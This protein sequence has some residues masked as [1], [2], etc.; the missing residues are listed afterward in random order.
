MKHSY[1][2][3]QGWTI[4]KLGWAKEALQKVISSVIPSTQ[5]AR[6]GKTD[7]E[8]MNKQTKKI[9]TTLTSESRIEMEIDGEG[10]WGNF[11]G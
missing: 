9:R 3:Q 11:M 4:K 6:R 7:I 8:W 5:H 1:M 2:Q 10:I